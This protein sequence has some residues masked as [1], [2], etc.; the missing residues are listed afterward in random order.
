MDALTQYAEKMNKIARILEAL[1]VW[2]E[3]MGGISPD[4]VAQAHVD[5]LDE[6][7]KMVRGAAARA[8]IDQWKGVKE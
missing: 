7:L 3:D 8:G 4:D 2:A 1:T 5:D 6:V